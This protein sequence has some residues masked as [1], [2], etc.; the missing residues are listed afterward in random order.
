MKNNGLKFVCILVHRCQEI[1]LHFIAKMKLM[2]YFYLQ[3]PSEVNQPW[4]TSAIQRK[5]YPAEWDQ[6]KAIINPQAF[7]PTTRKKSVC[8]STE[9]RMGTKYLS[10]AATTRFSDIFAAS[11]PYSI[12]MTDNS[13]VTPYCHS[14][15]KCKLY[16]KMGR[17]W[18]VYL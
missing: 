16:Q 18:V 15:T 1:L 10:A 3:I 7:R 14:H 9:H 4:Q 8:P 12:M 11:H 13:R 5:A 2:L 17:D 6:N